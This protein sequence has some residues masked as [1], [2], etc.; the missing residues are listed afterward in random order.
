MSRHDGGWVECP[1]CGAGSPSGIRICPRCRSR[2]DARTALRVQ[3][4]LSTDSAVA[5]HA[6][7]GAQGDRVLSTL[8]NHGSPRLPGQ[9]RIRTLMIVIAISAL[10]FACVAPWN[11]YVGPLCL[12][13]TAFLLPPI[14]LANWL[15]RKSRGYILVV[16]VFVVVWFTVLCLLFGEIII[17]LLMWFQGIIC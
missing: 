11:R 5:T 1:V 9:F 4:A 2:F 16:L 3:L 17:S 8:P 10:V 7:G 6:L 13:V 14:C 15:L 12:L